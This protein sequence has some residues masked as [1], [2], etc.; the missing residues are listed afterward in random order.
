MTRPGEARRDRIVDYLRHTER[1]T[2]REVAAAVGLQGLGALHSHLVILKER[3]IV[4]WD[5]VMLSRARTL[6]LVE[7]CIPGV[8]DGRPGWWTP[9]VRA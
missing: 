6:R 3:G 8:V 7:Q 4:K 1:P 5:T 9:E 2:I